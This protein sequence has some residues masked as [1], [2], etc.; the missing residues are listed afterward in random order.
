MIAVITPN[1]QVNDVREVPPPALHADGRNY[2]YR[3]L[4][5]NNRALADSDCTAELLSLLIYGYSEMSKKARWEA[6][7]SYARAVQASARTQVLNEI[8]VKEWSTLENWER[9]LLAWTPLTDPYGWGDGSTEPK[10]HDPDMPEQS[11]SKTE[12]FWVSKHPLI[13]LDITYEGTNAP[14][15]PVSIYGDQDYAPNLIFLETS[16]EKAFLHSLSRVGHIAFGEPLH[17]SL[18]KDIDLDDNSWVWALDS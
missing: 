18:L 13:L 12:D 15:R 6:R 17:S 9:E 7:I 16:E 10:E 5:D 3:M 4:F 8:S 14:N 1:P 2:L 11:V